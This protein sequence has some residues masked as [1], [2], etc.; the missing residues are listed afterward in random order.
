MVMEVQPHAFLTSALAGGEW[1]ALHL[2]LFNPG[3][4]ASPP[5]PSANWIGGWIGPRD[6]LDEVTEKRVLF[7]RCR[8]SNLGRLACSLLTILTELHRRYQWLHLHCIFNI[9]C[10]YMLFLYQNACCSVL[11]HVVTYFSLVFN[12]SLSAPNPNSVTRNTS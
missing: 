10:G 4:R 9:K 5:P 11:E 2:G 7:G 12:S 3:V 8:E 6:G 1:S